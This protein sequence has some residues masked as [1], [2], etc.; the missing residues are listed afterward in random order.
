MRFSELYEA[1]EGRW[2]S[3]CRIIEGLPKG[4]MFERWSCCGCDELRKADEIISGHCESELEAELSDTSQHG[5]REPADGLAL[6]ERLLNAL[7]F[8]LAHRVA[9]MAGGAGIDGGPPT[10]D[11][12]G[13]VRR[14]VERAHVGDECRR[15]I[16]LV[17]AKG[18]AT[19]PGEWRTIIA[20][21]ASRSAVPV[22]LVNVV[23]TMSPLRFS[24][25]A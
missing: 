2:K 25:S 17:G 8:L 12:L 5:P 11:I 14:H 9:G 10:A 6:S 7:S 3:L 20:S 4:W 13:D 15:V 24:I 23:A 19:S 16:A 1:F 21:A 18:D 22:A